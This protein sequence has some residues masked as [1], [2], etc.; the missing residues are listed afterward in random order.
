[1]LGSNVTFEKNQ[2]KRCL[3]CK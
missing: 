1:M 2:T 3:W